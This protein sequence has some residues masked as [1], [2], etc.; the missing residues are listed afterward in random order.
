MRTSDLIAAL[1]L[2]QKINK[3]TFPDTCTGAYLLHDGKGRLVLAA[4]D[5]HTLYWEELFNL[6]DGDLYHL[7][8]DDTRRD[9][10]LRFFPCRI[11]LAAIPKLVAVLKADRE[12]SVTIGTMSAGVITF[13]GVI[14]FKYGSGATIEAPYERANALDIDR[15]YRR[16]VLEP[17]KD[18]V[19]TG[20]APF[21]NWNSSSMKLLGEAFTPRDK[22]GA[23]RSTVRLQ[24]WGNP[25]K[26]K[27]DE[28]GEVRAYIERWFV[29]LSMDN[30]DGLSNE[31]PRGAVSMV[32]NGDEN[33]EYQN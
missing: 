11:P 17:E 23:A 27:N 3:N 32:V 15:L 20:M 2:T 18:F 9:E 1:N 4:L 29:S 33:R 21:F 13:T 16:M 30:M 8:L 5:G 14:T 10:E 19:M 31:N 22:R 7:L 28:T 25:G 12:Q 24:L 26:E 6:Q